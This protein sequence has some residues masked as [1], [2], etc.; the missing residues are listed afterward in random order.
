MYQII[1]EGTLSKTAIN[2]FIQEVLDQTWK[3][4]YYFCGYIISWTA[5]FAP[6]LLISFKISSAKTDVKEKTASLSTLDT[7]F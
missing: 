5:F 2:I 6:S 7:I 4:L 1:S 3:L